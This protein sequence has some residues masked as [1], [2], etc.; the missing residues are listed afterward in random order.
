MRSVCARRCNT[1]STASTAGMTC[2]SARPNDERPSAASCAAMGE[3]IAASECDI[4]EEVSCACLVPGMHFAQEVRGV[5]D[6]SYHVGSDAVDFL[7]QLRA[8]FVSVR[9]VKRSW[10]VSA[11]T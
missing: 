9:L 6:E 2:D 4:V 11:M 5:L 1:E 3:E 7:D 8:F 10:V